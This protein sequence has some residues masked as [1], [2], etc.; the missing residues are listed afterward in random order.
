M[1][2]KKSIYI[3][4]ITTIY[5]SSSTLIKIP[6]KIKSSKSAS[7]K[8]IVKIL[9]DMITNYKLFSLIE[10]G[11]PPQTIETFFD[12]KNSNFYISDVCDDCTLSYIYKHSKSFT[13]TDTEEKPYL[14]GTTFYGNE[15]L[16]FFDENNQR[17]G[18]DNMLI[19]LPELNK[20]KKV[21]CLNIGLKFPDYSNNK[22]QESFIQQVKHKNIINQYLW[23]I[24][25]Y[26][27]ENNINN[28]YDGEFIFGDVFTEYYPKIN[29]GKDFSYNDIVHTYG[30]IIKKKDSLKEEMSMQWGIQFDEIYYKKSKNGQDN[31]YIEDYTAEFSLNSKMIYGTTNYYTNIKN[32]YFNY[33]LNKNICKEAIIK[34]NMYKFIY[35]YAANFTINDIESFPTLNFDNKILRYIFTLDYKDLFTLTKDNKYYIFNVI[36]FNILNSNDND[37]KKWVFGI[38]FFKKYQ[39]NFDSDNKLIYYY[40]NNDN[41]NQITDK[42]NNENNKN[43]KNNIFLFISLFF[44]FIALLFFIII[45]IKKILLKKGFVLMRPKKANELIDDYD[46][47]SK[48]FNDIKEENRII[49]KE[50]EM[51]VK[52]KYY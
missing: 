19:F 18:I 11:Q 44:I 35:C 9:E 47:S 4:F 43:G 13:K 42:N 33:Y 23:T 48:N 1:I 10:I 38:P 24:S 34:F 39:L 20:N 16:Y 21:N 17:K 37:E 15:I 31:V 46:Y 8:S 2:L 29:K 36:V 49:N 32:D 45:I 40:I 26:D 25:F 3:F 27:D 41:K 22:F 52:V 51:Q 28:D 5:L 12:I 30:G 50:C 14:Y 6:F 7:N